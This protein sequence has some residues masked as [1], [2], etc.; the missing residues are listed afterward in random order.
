MRDQDLGSGHHGLANGGCGPAADP[1]QQDERTEQP[2]ADIER[3]HPLRQ[4]FGIRL[5][6]IFRDLDVGRDALNEHEREGHGTL[7]HARQVH[8]EI[9]HLAGRL[10][11]RQ[12]AGGESVLGQ[13]V[14]H[15]LAQ[16][17]L[18]AANP[19][20]VDR[21]AGRDVVALDGLAFAVGPVVLG[22]HAGHERHIVGG[23]PRRER[24]LEIRAGPPYGTCVLG[25]GYQDD[26]SLEFGKVGCHGLLLVSLLGR[27]IPPN[28]I[29]KIT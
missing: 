7:L 26:L 24:E 10:F 16:T 17:E 5:D 22:E 18:D 6:Q 3:A 13:E 2:R 19:V 20:A 21:I 12:R 23:V 29:P 28:G 15:P 1:V 4:R 8:E 9:D 14:K 25:P 11:A 27:P